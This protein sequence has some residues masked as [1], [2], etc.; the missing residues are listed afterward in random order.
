MLTSWREAPGVPTLGPNDLHVWRIDLDAF[1]ATDPSAA[2]GVG[3]GVGG[4]GGGGVGWSSLTPAEQERARRFRVPG[5]ARRWTATR[6]F[7]RRLLGRYLG[8]EPADVELVL[9]PHDKPAVDTAGT[10]GLAFNLS[11]SGGLALVGVT[12]A[13]AVGVDVEQPRDDLD[14]L[15]IAD[16][17]L[18]PEPS[19][20][21]R[22]LAP[23]DRAAAF[24]RLWVRH[25]AT[26]KC[27]GTGLGDEPDPSRVSTAMVTDIDVG[28]GY[29]AA[30]A[31]ERADALSTPGDWSTTWLWDAGSGALTD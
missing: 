18:G 31:V 8:V 24:F 13:G 20:R 26:V 7:L 5:D 3:G 17:A 30:V 15:A 1:D 19:R 2:P 11:H 29:H 10:L 27:L 4:G 22:A 9:G 14:L 21:L 6:V 25:E 12:R 16:L 28:P 23:P